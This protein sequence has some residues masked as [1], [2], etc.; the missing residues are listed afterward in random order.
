MRPLFR[1]LK[2]GRCRRVRIS[3]MDSNTLLHISLIMKGLFVMT[4]Q[5]VREII[6][7]TVIK[8]IP[9]NSIV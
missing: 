5:R 3:L 1:R 6:N 9:I 7:I 4:M 8:S 2:Y